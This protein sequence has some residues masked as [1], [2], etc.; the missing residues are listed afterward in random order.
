MRRTY[1]LAIGF[2]ALE[3]EYRDTIKYLVLDR[4]YYPYP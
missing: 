1:R 4:A 3:A 2:F